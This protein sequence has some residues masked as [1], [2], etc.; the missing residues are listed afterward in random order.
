MSNIVESVVITMTNR[1]PKYNCGVYEVFINNFNGV[2]QLFI[3]G[4]GDSIRAAHEVAA[5]ELDSN[6]E[7]ITKAFCDKLNYALS[8]GYFVTKEMLS[9]QDGRT[10]P[11][12]LLLEH[13]SEELFKDAVKSGIA[14]NVI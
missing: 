7:S 2:Y 5:L 10:L 8:E 6:I 14:R 9:H 11:L 1:L 12:T 3:S 13:F 4:K